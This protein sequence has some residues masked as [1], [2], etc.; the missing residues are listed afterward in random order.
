MAGGLEKAAKMTMKGLTAPLTL[1]VKGAAALFKATP[2]SVKNFAGITAL[3]AGAVGAAGYLAVNSRGTEFRDEDRQVA[4]IPPI[5]TPQDLMAPSPMLAREDGPA[6]GHG[7][8][9][10]RNRA[11]PDVAAQQQVAAS[12]PR[13]SAVAADNVAELGATDG[14]KRG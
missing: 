13:M 4:M 9:E 1:P 11:R 14:A 12:N 7:E 2:K 6:E 3:V 10:W 5:L 8:Y